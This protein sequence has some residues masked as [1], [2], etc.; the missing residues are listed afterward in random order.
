MRIPNY[1]VEDDKVSKFKQL[2]DF[3]P[4]INVSGCWFAVQVV[5]GKLIH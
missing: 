2:Y 1:D 4:Q 3:M 5:Q